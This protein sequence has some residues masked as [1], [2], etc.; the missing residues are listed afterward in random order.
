MARPRKDAA[1]EEP[2]EVEREPW[3][4]VKITAYKVQTS[5]GRF[6]AGDFADLP[7]H[8]A[9]QLIADGLAK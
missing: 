3:R 5:H 9:D 1:T 7:G 8:I 2:H 6:I 4:R